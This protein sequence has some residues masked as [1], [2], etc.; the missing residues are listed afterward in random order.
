MPDGKELFNGKIKDTGILRSLN[1]TP[2]EFSLALTVLF[3]TYLAF[4][5]TSNL[6]LET[7]GLRK[8]ILTLALTWG[9]VAT[10]QG[11]VPSKAGLYVN[12]IFLVLAE[13]G[14]TPGI[15]ILL[16]FFNVPEELQLRRPFT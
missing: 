15:T 6:K 1:M 9:V 14:L 12:R 10:L 3:P 5:L 7:I 4:Q 13:A 2:Y 11:L 16:T 8:W